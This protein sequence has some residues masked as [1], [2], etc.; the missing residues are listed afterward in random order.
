M[1]E[2]R[3]YL[4]TIKTNVTTNHVVDPDTGELLDSNIEVKEEKILVENEKEFLQL[5]YSIF[6]I[7]GKLSLAERSVLL[8]LSKM[9]D[10]ENKITIVK[11]VKE[12]IAE[13]TGLSYQ[14]INNCVSSLAKK[15]VIVK[16]GQAVY[17][18]NPRYI[19]KSTSNERSKTLKYMLEVECRNC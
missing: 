2:S 19:W 12:E 7:L 17:R 3:P 18:L 1:G 8:Y 16:L 13:E 11:Y 6:G 15:A 10:K 4:K 5:Y 14:T 9:C